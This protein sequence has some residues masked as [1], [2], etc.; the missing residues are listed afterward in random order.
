[1]YKIGLSVDIHQLV[2]N[3]E[4][5]LGGVKIEHELGLLGHSDADVVLHSIGESIIGALGLNDLGSHFPDTDPKYKGISSIVILEHIYQLMNSH[6]FEINNIDVMILC[7]APK[8][9]PHLPKMKEKIANVLCCDPSLVNLKAT[10]GEKIG[11]VGRQE[12]ICCQTVTMLKKLE[13]NY[14]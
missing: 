11:F 1:M 6:Q 7:Q 3:R 12:G 4:L 10:T 8:L 9:A 5:I 14:G 2:S 13:A